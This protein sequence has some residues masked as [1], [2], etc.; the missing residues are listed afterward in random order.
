VGACTQHVGVGAIVVTNSHIRPWIREYVTLLYADTTLRSKG[1]NGLRT[2]N[3][4]TK[5]SSCL[6]PVPATLP[7]TLPST[8]PQRKYNHPP[9]PLSGDL[10][11][12]SPSHL[13]PSP[14]PLLYTSRYL[15]VLTTTH[16]PP[17]SCLTFHMPLGIY[18][19][20]PSPPPSFTLHM[21]SGYLQNPTR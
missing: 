3:H 12:H 21:P 8:F 18:N 11:P 17:P 6:I 16:T 10:Q 7:L 9:P 13:L 5:N 14:S 1:N 2:T 19:L 15:R 20:P 4:H